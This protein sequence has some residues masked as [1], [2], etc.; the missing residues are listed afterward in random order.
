MLVNIAVHTRTH[1]SLRRR[2]LLLY[3]GELQNIAAPWPSN[4]ASI[5]ADI[6][7]VWGS[8][9][10]WFESILVSIFGDSWLSGVP[11]EFKFGSN[12]GPRWV[13]H[14]DRYQRGGHSRA[15]AAAG[16]HWRALADTG[17]HWRALAGTGGHWR[18]L[19]RTWSATGNQK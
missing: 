1:R 3:P 18:A 6:L 4:L 5:S 7:N 8:N 13:W 19:V 9:F 12:V 16:G 15:L 10:G 17:G 11:F 2:R 14:R